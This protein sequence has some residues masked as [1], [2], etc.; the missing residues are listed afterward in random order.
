MKINTFLILLILSWS[1]E[2]KELTDNLRS[3]GF[4]RL[5]EAVWNNNKERVKTLVEDGTPV[6]IASESGITPLHSASISNNQE[7]AALLI[8]LGANIEARDK[9]GRTPLFIAAEV[10]P[11]PQQI[12]MLLINNRACTTQKSNYDKTR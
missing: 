7:I 11:D 8:A 10:N 9:Q 4:T 5:H 3:A 6:D 1:C 2:S 12:L